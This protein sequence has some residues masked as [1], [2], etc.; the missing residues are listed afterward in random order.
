MRCLIFWGERVGGRRSRAVRAVRIMCW[1]SDRWTNTQERRG[2]KERGQERKREKR[3]AKRK[4]REDM[5]SEREG[6]R[7]TGRGK[8]RRK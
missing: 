3:E 2:G 8:K 7:G 1:H 6:E 5:R 4:R